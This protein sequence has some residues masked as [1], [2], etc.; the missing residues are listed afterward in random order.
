MKDAQKYTLIKMGHLKHLDVFIRDEN[1]N[2]RGFVAY[3][4]TD[5]H[6]D[7]LVHDKDGWVRTNLACYGNEKHAK[8]L[9]NGSNSA[10]RNT[11][12]GRLQELNELYR[13]IE[14]SK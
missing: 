13:S 14:Y 3:Y 9:L 11:A 7:Q 10:V 6:R 2:V 4:G 12:N 1:F 5:K 8:A